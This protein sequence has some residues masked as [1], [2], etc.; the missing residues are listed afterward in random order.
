[1]MSIPEEAHSFLSEW[2]QSPER[3]RERQPWR[4]EEEGQI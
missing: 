2:V 4:R 3:E 1:M